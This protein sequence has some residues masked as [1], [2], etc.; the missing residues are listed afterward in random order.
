VDGDV[1]LEPQGKRHEG[2]DPF[3]LPEGACTQYCHG[4]CGLP[5]PCAIYEGY[6][7]KVHVCWHLPHSTASEGKHWWRGY[8]N[9][10]CSTRSSIE[11][12]EARGTMVPR[13]TGEI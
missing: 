1:G 13:R 6:R 3:A 12:G 5:D 2:K 10:P 7:H 8:E 4:P 9:V 11:F